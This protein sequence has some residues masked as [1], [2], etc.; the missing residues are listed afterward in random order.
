MT[1]GPSHGPDLTAG[2][3]TLLEL[4]VTIV[5]GGLLLVSLSQGTRF[6][7]LAWATDARLTRGNDDLQIMDS[8]VRHLIQGM[9]PGAVRAPAPMAGGGDRFECLTALPN[10]FGAS[11]SRRM[12]AELL[13]DGDHRLVLRWRPYL[14]ATRL[15]PMPATRDTELLSGVSRIAV[16]YWSPSGSWVSTWHGGQLPT[17]VRVRLWFPDGDPRRWPDIVA[18]PG[19]EH[20]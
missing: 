19:L 20:E 17:L 6:G 3:F 9:D 5:V 16:S 11:P 1:L 13:V 15:G 7:L 12:S 2:G 10:G 8:T 14:R 4:L 18:A